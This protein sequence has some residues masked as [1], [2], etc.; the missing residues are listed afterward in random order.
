MIIRPPPNPQTANWFLKFCSTSIVPG[1]IYVN[2]RLVSPIHFSM[3]VLL[4][5]SPASH[6]APIFVQCDLSSEVVVYRQS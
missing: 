2:K 4:Q 6:I 5:G 3:R 1:I